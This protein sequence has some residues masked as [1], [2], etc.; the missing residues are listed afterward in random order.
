M[1]RLSHAIHAVR[2][3]IGA[4]ARLALILG[5]LF[6][7][8]FVAGGGI[9]QNKRFSIERIEIEGSDLGTLD[10]VRSLVRQKLEGN[11]FFVYARK[12]SY[13]YPRKEIEEMILKTFP[14][15]KSVRVEQK[16]EHTIHVS[17]LERKPYATWCGEVY[18]PERSSLPECWFIDE[19]GFVFDRAPVFSRGVYVEFYGKLLETNQGEPLRASIS[20]LRFR[21][22][23]DFNKS[24]GEK[25]GK[26]FLVE[27]KDEGEI[28][29]LVNGAGEFS[30]IKF[31]QV[32]FKDDTAPTILVKNIAL[33]LPV[34]FA[35]EKARKKTLNY[36]D[37]RFGNKV[38]FGFEN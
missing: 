14:R 11:Y 24:F 23:N 35:D 4:W 18:H 37:L 26:V 32:R 1:K 13:L 31:V 34:E 3:H 6:C 8:F 28:Q 10:T 5:V 33:A 29:A 25:I 15:M 12:N 38:I 17:L 30:Y 21:V 2:E 20:P 9:S 16:D 22:M 19:D 36:I 7:L 27:Y